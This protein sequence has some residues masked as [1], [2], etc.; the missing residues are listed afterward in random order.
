MVNNQPQ[1]V[2]NL[3]VT[4]LERQAVH[5]LDQYTDRETRKANI[6]IQNLPESKQDTAS[7]KTVEDIERVED[8][9]YRGINVDG[10]KIT[11]LIR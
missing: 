4:I 6:I 5:I 11:K 2:Q 7:N 3:K 9:L 1:G 8:M 10:V